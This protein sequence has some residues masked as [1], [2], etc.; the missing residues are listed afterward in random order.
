MLSRR[1]LLRAGTL[2]GLVIAA[3]GL[4]AGC[5]DD[6]SPPPKDAADGIRLVS[7][8]VARTTVAPAAI[9]TGAGTVLALGAGLYGQ[10]L[11]EPGTWL[12]RRTPRPS[13]SA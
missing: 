3:P 8:D 7:S 4:F 6:G 9:G 11:G 13:P 1:E 10:L 2:G 5:S 12:C